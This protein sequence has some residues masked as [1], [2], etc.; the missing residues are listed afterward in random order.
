MKT[1][2]IQILYRLYYVCFAPGELPVTPR[3]PW[4]ENWFRKNDFWTIHSGTIQKNQRPLPVDAPWK[5]SI[6]DGFNHSWMLDEWPF[7][8]RILRNQRVFRFSRVRIFRI[9]ENLEFWRFEPINLRSFS[10]WF[11]WKAL[12][13]HRTKQTTVYEQITFFIKNLNFSK[14]VFDLKI[15]F[16]LE[17]RFLDSKSL[18]K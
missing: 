11:P 13:S 8:L 14:I 5:I 1:Q 17:N 12:E 18:E 16:W 6:E 2:N 15:D 3:A 9:F 4:I 7:H 10:W